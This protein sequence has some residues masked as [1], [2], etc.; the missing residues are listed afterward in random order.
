MTIDFILFTVRFARIGFHRI[1]HLPTWQ[2]PMFQV[3]IIIYLTEYL[4]QE[5]R[6]ERAGGIRTFTGN[7]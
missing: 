4:S 2:I 3:T 7:R 5:I 1:E 6:W